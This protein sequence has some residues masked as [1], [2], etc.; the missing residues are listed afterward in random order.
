MVVRACLSCWTGWNGERLLGKEDPVSSPPPNHEGFKGEA[1]WKPM[2]LA[3]QWRHMCWV[4]WTD[5]CLHYDILYQR[6]R[7]NSL[8][9]QLQ[10]NGVVHFGDHKGMSD[11]KQTPTV[12]SAIDIQPIRISSEFC[13]KKSGRKVASDKGCL[14]MWCT[15]R[16]ILLEYYWFNN[17]VIMKHKKII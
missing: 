7:L 6:K 1:H 17:V 10:C 8:R 13:K 3:K 2:Q 11:Y 14:N 16:K 5:H 15:S 4:I 9:Q 12:Q